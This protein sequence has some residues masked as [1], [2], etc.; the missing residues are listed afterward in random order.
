MNKPF[1]Y[2]PDAGSRQI[3]CLHFS[4]ADAGKPFCDC[5]NKAYCLGVKGSQDRCSFRIPITEAAKSK[6]PRCQDPTP[7]AKRIMKTGKRDTDPFETAASISLEEFSMKAA[8]LAAEMRRQDCI[9][10]KAGA[11]PYLFWCFYVLGAWNGCEACGTV[12]GKAFEL[13]DSLV[14]EFER[15]LRERPNLIK[16]FNGLFTVEYT[17]D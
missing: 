5:L 4:R 3:D 6:A 7:K 12:N 10:T 13:N 11:V 16:Q 14:S 8:R 17:N 1:E 9:L 2:A 15:Q